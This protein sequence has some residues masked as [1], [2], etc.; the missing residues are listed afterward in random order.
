MRELGIGLKGKYVTTR[1]Q[2]AQALIRI[3]VLNIVLSTN[4]DI[5]IVRLF[6]NNHGKLTLDYHNIRNYSENYKPLVTVFQTY[7]KG[8][9]T[10]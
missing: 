4:P 9:R 5:S 3:S 10:V 1:D 7:F 8:A 2:R 6:R